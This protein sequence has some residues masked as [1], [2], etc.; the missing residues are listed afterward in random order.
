MMIFNIH[1]E[2]E[3][4]KGKQSEEEDDNLEEDEDIEDEEEN[5]E[6]FKKEVVALVSNTDTIMR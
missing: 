1:V 4:E 2:E 5:E 3:G 6:P